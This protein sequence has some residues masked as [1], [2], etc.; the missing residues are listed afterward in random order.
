MFDYQEYLD[1]MEAD[2]KSELAT[3]VMKSILNDIK[4]AKD[5]CQSQASLKYLEI[6]FRIVKEMIKLEEASGGNE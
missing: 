2:K 5:L 1:N 6:T 3:N 4:F